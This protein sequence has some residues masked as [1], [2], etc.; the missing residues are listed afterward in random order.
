MFYTGKSTACHTCRVRR[1]KCDETRPHCLKCQRAGRDCLGYRDESGFIIRDMTSDTIKRFNK[2]RAGSIE[3][4]PGVGEPSAA[5]ITVAIRPAAEPHDVIMQGNHPVL[6]DSL[7]HSLDSVFIEDEDPLEEEKSCGLRLGRPSSRSLRF[8]SNRA[9]FTIGGFLSLPLEDQAFCYFANRYA[10]VPTQ[11]LDPGYLPVLKHVSHRKDAGRCLSYSLSAVS[12]AAFATRQN[13]RKSIVRARSAYATALKYT[14]EAIRKPHSC[15]DDELLASVILLALFEV[16]SSEDLTGWCSHIYG[17][18]AMLGAR[19]T[20]RSRSKF[21]EALFRVVNNESLKLSMMGKSTPH[22][23]T[24]SWL[25]WL[26]D[27]VYLTYITPDADT[28]DT[29]DDWSTVPT[30]DTEGATWQEMANLKASDAVDSVKSGRIGTLAV[31][32]LAN[33]PG[34]DTAGAEPSDIV[35]VLQHSKSIANAHE[36]YQQPGQATSLA[37]PREG[38]SSLSGN[39]GPHYPNDDIFNKLDNSY[40]SLATASLH[41]CGCVARLVNFN[42]MARCAAAVGL[43]ATDDYNDAVQK[44]RKEIHDIIRL[45]PYFYGLMEQST[46]AEKIGSPSSTSSGYTS[47]SS[48]GSTES[49]DSWGDLDADDRIKVKPRKPFANTTK[50]YIGFMILWP[51]ATTTSTDLIDAEQAEY[52]DKMQKYIAESCGIKIAEGVRKFVSEQRR[53]SGAPFFK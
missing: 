11:F 42:V 24:E 43:G 45:L 30:A 46:A 13:A 5:D 26:N 1:L 52:I 53:L 34:A 27:P 49:S 47:S 12:L 28:F 37:G 14:N 44:G 6:P 7:P 51:I 33:I 38:S 21:G 2:R 9:Q 50:S 17:A 32:Q 16:F 25:E 15:E 20:V 40:E 29:E 39:E 18:A 48:E 19:K 22:K 23:G 31:P 35:R 41:I 4:R 3:S 8:K 10:F 36:R